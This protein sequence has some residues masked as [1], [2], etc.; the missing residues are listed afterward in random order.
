MTELLNLGDLYVSDFVKD[1]EEPRGGRVELKLVFDKRRTP[2]LEKTAPPNTMYGKYWYRSGVNKTMRR[3]LKDI[4][5]SIT[6]LYNLHFGDVWLDIACNDGTLFQYIPKGIVRVGIDPADYSYKDESEERAYTIIQDYFSAGVYR[7][8]I[9]KTASVITSIAMFYDVEDNESF[10][11]DVY[12]VLHPDGLWVMQLSYTP[13]MIKQL[14]FDNICHEHIY[15]YS[16]GDIKQL[17]NEYGF[18]IMDCQINDVNG[19]SF[20]LY[21]MKSVGDKTLFG[22]QPHR[23]VCEFRVNA[24]L[25]YESSLFID[26]P[27]IWRD[28]YNDIEKLKETTVSFIKDVVAKGK[29]VMGYG[30]STKGNTLLQYFDLDNTLITAIADR[31]P[32]KWGLKTAGTDITIISEEEMR[33][34][35]P[36]YLLIL[37]WHFI[38][39][40]QEREAE[41]IR[42]G[43]KFIVPCPQFKII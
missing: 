1:G 30:A 6:S 9:H 22:T 10:L 19:G 5:K 20:R 27:K 28:F 17:L 16:L 41:Y 15:Y 35:H 38:K 37:P 8:K 13:L 29:V 18:T 36:D 43:G 24:L 23:G 39:E 25:Q 26:S 3:A 2:R 12:E 21:I 33:N 34:I 40:F 7:D 14:A 4:V 31:N 42:K 11:K 32:Q